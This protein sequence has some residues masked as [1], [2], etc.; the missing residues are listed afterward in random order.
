MMLMIAL[1][2]MMAIE[3]DGMPQ[4]AVIFRFYLGSCQKIPNSSNFA[5][6][7]HRL[8]SLKIVLLSTEFY[9]ITWKFH[10]Q[11]NVYSNIGF[12][13]AISFDHAVG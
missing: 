2:M 8:K 3:F 7:P 12:I 6:S 4:T 9:R 13:L 11:I 5:F 10:K 1:V